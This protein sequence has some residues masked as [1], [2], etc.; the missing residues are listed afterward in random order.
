MTKRFRSEYGSADEGS[1]T[2]SDLPLDEV[3]GLAW[4]T[5]TCVSMRI[6]WL[7]LPISLTVITTALA[8]WTIAS[9]WRHRH[10]RP[11]WKDS[12]LPLM[13]Y[14]SDIVNGALD[15]YNHDSKEQQAQKQNKSQAGDNINPLDIKSMKEVAESIDVTFTWLYGTENSNEEPALSKRTK[16]SWRRNTN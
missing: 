13:F 8:I 4:Q 9:N 12:I 14:G 1:R 16:W 5:T 2:E 3:Q 6:A 15:G 7:L 10:S 11:V